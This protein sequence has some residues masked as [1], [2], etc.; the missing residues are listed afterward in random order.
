VALDEITTYDCLC[1]EIPATIEVKH[2]KISICQSSR[3][4]SK[5]EIN[6]IYIPELNVSINCEKENGNGYNIILDSY[7]R[8]SGET[9][10]LISTT[11][12]ADKQKIS[13]IYKLVKSFVLSNQSVQA[14]DEIFE[15]M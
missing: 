5:Y 6:E 12:I 7:Y 8:F 9:S 10:K 1:S 2:Y 13:E 11:T 3:N 14:I 15:K 4:L